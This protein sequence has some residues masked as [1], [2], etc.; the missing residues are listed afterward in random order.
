MRPDPP[1]RNLGKVPI[2]IRKINTLS[3]ALPVHA[4]DDRD[5]LF[6]EV[7][8]PLRDI[9]GALDG[10]TEV[11]LQALTAASA[12]FDCVELRDDLRAGSMARN[13]AAGSSDICVCLAQLEE[14]ESC[15]A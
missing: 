9:V 8:F 1:R 10:D 3:T 6:L 11:L 7:C 15:I 5:P 12:R 13:D 2:E 14:E 4:A